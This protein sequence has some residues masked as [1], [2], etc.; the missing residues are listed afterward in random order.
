[1]SD[2]PKRIF[3]LLVCLECSDLDRPLVMPFDSA[4][5]RGKWAAAHTKG[6]GHDRWYVE[7]EEQ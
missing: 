6:T 5:A 4:E 7:D 1:M 2:Q 3:Y